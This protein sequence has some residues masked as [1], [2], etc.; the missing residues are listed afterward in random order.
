MRK[1]DICNSCVIT[2]R[3]SCNGGGFFTVHKG[4]TIR[5]AEVLIAL[6]LDKEEDK[7]PESVRITKKI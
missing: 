2:G 4:S 7:I 1:F 5:D 3:D 6:F